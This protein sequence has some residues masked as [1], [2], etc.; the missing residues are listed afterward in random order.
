MNPSFSEFFAFLFPLLF[1]TWVVYGI[2]S[3]TGVLRLKEQMVKPAIIV[4]SVVIT[5]YPFAGF[6]LAEYLLSLN[7]NY[8]VG[9]IALLS[10]ILWKELGGKQLLPEKDILWF[11]IWNVVVSLFLFASY[12]GFIDFDLYDLGYRFSVLFF[13]TALLTILFFLFRSP[14]SYIFIGYILVFD[15]RLLHSDNFFDYITDGVLFLIS[16]GLLV[17]YGVK[18]IYLS[19]FFKGGDLSD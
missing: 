11:C 13:L 10:V 4:I 15:L 6:S 17:F 18:F 9:S 1:I 7:P 2:A 5:L 19:P 12:L 14:L 3:F 8:S 16:M